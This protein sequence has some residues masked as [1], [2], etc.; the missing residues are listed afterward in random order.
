ML[1]TVYGH[2]KCERELNMLTDLVFNISV[3]FQ[4][5]TSAVIYVFKPI[6]TQ[7]NAPIPPRHNDDNVSS[8]HYLQPQNDQY[9]YETH[10]PSKTRY[11]GIYRNM[12]RELNIQSGTLQL[13][14]NL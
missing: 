1:H 12:P 10:V 8:I 6:G 2:K 3:R 5:V 7:M 4:Q 13:A 9:T 14:H 11:G